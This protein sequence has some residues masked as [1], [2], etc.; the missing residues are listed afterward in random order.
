MRVGA[1][2]Q[3]SGGVASQQTTLS[4]PTVRKTRWTRGPT[5]GGARWHSPTLSIKR[6]LKAA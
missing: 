2:I 4:R 1:C 3:I 5:D 6:G